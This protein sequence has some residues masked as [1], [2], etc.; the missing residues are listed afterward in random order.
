M[1][2]YTTAAQVLRMLSAADPVS[3]NGREDPLRTML[4]AGAEACEQVVD[5]GHEGTKALRTLAEVRRLLI[6]IIDD[7]DARMATRDDLWLVYML[8]RRALDCSTG[9]LA[10]DELEQGRHE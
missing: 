8:A 6:Q 4:R 2:R 7:L 3:L 9:L 5:A 1:E 10:S